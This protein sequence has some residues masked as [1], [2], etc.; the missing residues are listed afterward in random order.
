LRRRRFEHYL[1]PAFGDRLRHGWR[2]IGQKNQQQRQAKAMAGNRYR[3][4]KL[5]LAH[6]G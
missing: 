5:D 3:K 1:D 6:F 2:L 4:R